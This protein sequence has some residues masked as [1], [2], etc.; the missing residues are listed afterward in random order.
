LSGVRPV[1]AVTVVE[2]PV[3]Q[4]YARKARIAFMG[5]A[6]VLGVVVAAVLAVFTN[7]VWAVVLGAVVGVVAGFVA[8]VW[9]WAWPVLRVLWWWSTEITL[10][11]AVVWAPSLLARVDVPVV[12]GGDCAD[13]VCGVRRGRPGAPVVGGVVVVSGGA[14]PAAAVFRRVRPRGRWYPS[15]CV[16]AGP[17]GPA[18]ACG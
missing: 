6:G 12:G 14:S 5:V 16:A 17:V 11:L 4:W 9:M 15:G 1:G 13:G 3:S 8:A 18:D 10:L 7:P 2:P